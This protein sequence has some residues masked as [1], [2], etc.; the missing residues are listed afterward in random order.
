ML[1]LWT[2]DQNV[3]RHAKLAAVEFLTSGNVL[4]G[5]ALGTL[6]QVS[7]VVNPPHLAQFFVGMRVEPGTLTADGVG[8]QD[9]R[10]QARSGDTRALKDLPA[11][12]QRGLKIHGIGA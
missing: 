3:R 1:R 9:F 2:W 5:F 7:A 10:G 8:K 12:Q 11:L 6:V 4:R